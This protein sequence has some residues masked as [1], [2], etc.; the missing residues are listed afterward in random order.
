MPIKEIKHPRLDLKIPSFSCD[1]SLN[2]ILQRYPM[3]S[4]LDNYKLTCLIGLPASGKTSLLISWL[5]GKGDKKVFRKVFDSVLVCMPVAS[6]SSL[7]KNIFKNHPAE[8][9]FNELNNDSMSQIY[10]SLQ[11][12]SSEKKSTL[13]ILD[14]VGASLRQNEI[15]KKLK[16]I[17]Y[18][19]RHM[20]VHIIML[21]QS[22]ISMPR[23][24]RKLI[25]N[26]ILFKPSK[27]EAE[28]L[29]NELFEMDKH[30]VLELMRY[31][32]DKPHQYLF[33]NVQDQKIYKDYNELL[34]KNNLNNSIY[35]SSE[36]D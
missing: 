12:Y 35:D 33:L 26:A 9:L 22:Y 36:E 16:E 31:A 10:E 5:T 8:K 25:N 34:I 14:D 27:V 4:N 3:L 17:V 21:M 13:L 1:G 23:E 28:T 6:R 11:T 20:R 15:Q 30:D 18:N 19:R 2:P 32:Y 24:I 7:K 29:L